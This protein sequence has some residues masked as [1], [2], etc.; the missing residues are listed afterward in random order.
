MNETSEHGI[1]STKT[2]YHSETLMNFCLLNIHIKIDQNRIQQNQLRYY[3]MN[4][5]CMF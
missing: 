2:S 3:V 5:L 1:I 4:S